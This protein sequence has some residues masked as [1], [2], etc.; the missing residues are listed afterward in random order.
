MQA[1]E[2][3]TFSRN[4]RVRSP[5]SSRI[6]GMIWLA[7]QGAL[8]GDAA[9]AKLTLARARQLAATLSSD[10]SKAMAEQALNEAAAEVPNP[11]SMTNLNQEQTLSRWA[12]GMADAHDPAGALAVA[13]RI[14]DAQAR[15]GM[16]AAL[17]ASLP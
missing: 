12:R 14:S 17:R 5:Y 9:S 16:L 6:E 3:M 4:D 13:A 10:D 2:A 8:R 7:R 15:S 1:L 11:A